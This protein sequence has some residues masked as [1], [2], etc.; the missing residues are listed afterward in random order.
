M[1]S[2]NETAAGDECCG[3]PEL[4]GPCPE[5]RNPEVLK[6]WREKQEKEEAA[7]GV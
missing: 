7:D 3:W 5:C 6:W 2:N 4:G 1:T